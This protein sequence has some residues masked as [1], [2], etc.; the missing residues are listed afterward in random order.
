MNHVGTLTRIGLLLCCGLGTSAAVA[1][2]PDGHIYNVNVFSSFGTQFNDCLV[3]DQRSGTLSIAGYGK[4]IYRHD[5]LNTQP[6]AWQATSPNGSLF[7]LSF[8]GT[9][10]GSGGQTIVANGL[11]EFGDT[12]ILQGVIAERGCAPAATRLRGS[13]YKR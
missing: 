7:I 10:G 4:A 11:N 6:E 8:H 3:F 2:S 9:V 5:E 1:H 12:F 13:P